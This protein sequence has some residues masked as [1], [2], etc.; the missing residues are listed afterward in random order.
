MPLAKQLSET[1]KAKIEA[2]R[3]TGWS[4]RKIAAKLGRDD[5]TVGN[6]V[7]KR[8][9]YGLKKRKGRPPKLSERDKRR[10]IKEASN[11]TKFLNQI[12]SNIGL[13]VHKSTISRVIKKNKKIVRAKMMSKPKLTDDYERARVEFARQ[14]M[15]TNWNQVNIF[16]GGVKGTG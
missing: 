9:Q 10:I 13:Q 14:N 3:D 11:S 15:G 2:Y 1:E 12:K 5:K 6:F 8:N 16:I 4:F 7:T